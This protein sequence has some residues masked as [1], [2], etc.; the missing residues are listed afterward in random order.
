LTELHGKLNS[1]GT[2][3]VPSTFAM[4]TSVAIPTCDPNGNNV[5]SAVL[6]ALAPRH[7]AAQHYMYCTTCEQKTE[8]VDVCTEQSTQSIIVAFF[9]A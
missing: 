2:I 4:K 7:S 3:G 9:G 8:D 5:V 1:G 6:A